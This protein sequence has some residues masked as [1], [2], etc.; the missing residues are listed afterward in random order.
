MLPESETPLTVRAAPSTVTAKADAPG[1]DTSSRASLQAKT[2][3][4]PFA[5]APPTASTGPFVSAANAALATTFALFK[6]SITAPAGSVSV[7]SASIPVAG[8]ISTS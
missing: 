4:A 3:D 8:S 2:S 1:A 6:A 5:A 7:T